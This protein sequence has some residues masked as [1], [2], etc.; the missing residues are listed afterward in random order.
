MKIVAIIQARMGSK[1]LPG[2]VLA[3]IA[4]LPMIARV[5][6]RV[7]CVRDLTQIIIATSTSAADDILVEWLE[8]HYSGYKIFRGSENDVLDRYYQCAKFYKVDLI[9]RITADDPLKD[10]GIIQRAIDCFYKDD[11]LDYCSNTLLPTYPEG[12]DVEVFKFKA[13]EKAWCEAKLA[14][15]REHVTP[16][17]WKNTK[18]FKVKNFRYKINLSHWRWTVDKP[19]D[20]EFMTQVYQYFSENPNIHFEKIIEYIGRNPRVSLINSGTVRNEGYLKSLI[21]DKNR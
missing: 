14:S 19:E 1:R 2:K 11:A 5:L 7:S 3:D 20:L 12:L 13:L 17:I 8:K 9:V 18:L 4:G 16:F 6:Q 21:E 10:A 15:E